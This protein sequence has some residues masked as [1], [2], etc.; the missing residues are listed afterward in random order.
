[1]PLL[2]AA[3]L[4]AELSRLPGWSV[5]NGALT[6]Q[7]TVRSF[8]HGVLFT[9][10]IAQLAEAAGHHPDV[11]LHDYKYVTVQ[12]VTHSDGGITDKDVSLAAQIEA[13]PH[14]PLAKA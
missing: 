4:Q 6:K 13:L 7:Y 12:L 1:M 9:G 11:R 2:S 14:K 10:A 5:A 3:D 8:A